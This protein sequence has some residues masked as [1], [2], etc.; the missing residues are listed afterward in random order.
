MKVKIFSAHLERA[1]ELEIKMIEWFQ[2]RPTI[3]II[4]TAQTIEKDILV[5]TIFYEG[6]LK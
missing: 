6:K 5:I 3:K 2:D 4:N 1:D